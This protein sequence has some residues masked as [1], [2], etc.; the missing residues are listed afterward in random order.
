MCRLNMTS[1][2]ILDCSIA[3]EPWIIRSTCLN[4][5]RLD[6]AV[7]EKVQ[8]AVHLFGVAVVVGALT[9]DMLEHLRMECE[10]ILE[11]SGAYDRY[12]SQATVSKRGC[13]FEVSRTIKNLNYQS[14]STLTV[15]FPFS[16]CSSLRVP[17]PFD[18]RSRTECPNDVSSSGSLRASAQPPHRVLGCLGYQALVVAALK[19]ALQAHGDIVWIENHNDSSSSP[20]LSSSS[21]VPS[22]SSSPSSSSVPSSVLPLSSRALLLNEQFIVKPPRSR[23]AAFRIHRDSDWCRNSDSE[24]E[25]DAPEEGEGRWDSKKKEV[26]GAVHED[27][28]INTHSAQQKPYLDTSAVEESTEGT[29]VKKEKQKTKKIFLKGPFVSAWT[30]L[31]PITESNGSFTVFPGSHFRQPSNK[32]TGEMNVDGSKRT[33]ALSPKILDGDKIRNENDS[34]TKEAMEKKGIR[35][36]LPEGTLV[37]MANR[38]LHGSGGNSERFSRRLIKNLSE[39]A[40]LMKYFASLLPVAHDEW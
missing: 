29:A 35:L 20:S 25:S 2:Q 21:S 24:S 9:P 5:Y 3:N 13:I 34:A 37:F 33:R 15:P 28:K 1:Q 11:I 17:L 14:W 10:T 18:T 4:Y 32:K 7:C 31:D 8:K 40:F 38:L 39:F 27:K 12:G 30:C 23:M 36:L 26:D 6:A 22:S 16:C 19:G